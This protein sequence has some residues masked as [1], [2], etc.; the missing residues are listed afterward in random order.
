MWEAIITS[1]EIAD[2]FSDGPEFFSTFGGSTLSCV[3]GKEVLEI[4]DDE[5]LQENAQLM[6]EKLLNGLKKIQG[7]FSQIG[8]VRGMGLFLGVDLVKNSNTQ[9]EDKDLC[10][11]IKSRMRDYRILIGSEGPKDNILKIRPPL[12]IDSDG[13][14]MILHILKK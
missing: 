10:N 2:S 13:I 6:G 5:C 8:D 4:I 7:N 12:T 14:D 3:I 1:K 11:Y 9:E